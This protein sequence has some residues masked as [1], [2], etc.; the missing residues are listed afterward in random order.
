MNTRTSDA[1]LLQRRDA[2]DL[3]MCD[4]LLLRSQGFG[5]LRLA[6]VLRSL[7]FWRFRCFRGIVH[8][9]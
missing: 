2:T 5:I 4:F 8:P 3:V 7:F 9:L 1:Y 6:V